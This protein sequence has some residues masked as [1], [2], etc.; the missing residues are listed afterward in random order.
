LVDSKSFRTFASRK[1]KSSYS[2]LKLKEIRIMPAN[3]EMVNGVASFAENGKRERAWHGLGQVV[4]EPMFVADALKLCHADFNVG[5]QPVVALSQELIEAMENHTF[6]NA[7]MLKDLLVENTM[8]TMRQDTNKSLGI[9]SDKYGIVQNVDA[10]KFVDLFCSGEKTDR[11]HTPVIETCG[12]LG[13]GERI[14]V[15]AKFPKPIVLDAKRDDLVEMYVVFTT[16]HDGTGAVR[17]VCTPVRVVCNNTLN[18]AMK[19]NIG[20]IAFRHSSKVMDRLDLLNAENAE[21]AYKALNVAEVYANGLKESF[22]HLRNIK[23]AE[24]D[25]DNIIAQVVLSDEA[26]KEFMQTRNIESELIKTRGRNI[27][28]GV[29]ECL[30]SGIGQEGQ[31][32]GTAMWLMNGLTSFYQNEATERSNE[33][34][35]DSILDGN[36]YKKVQKAY[37][38]AIAA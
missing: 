31:E 26:A 18:W 38:L 3:I 5:L 35:F 34:K 13:K 29:K 4:E 11:D 6:I 33:I 14:F 24:R 12:V 27:F 17:C 19:E 28:L 30:E 7:S 22:D 36:I 23:L 16:T 37:D 2:Q 8:A 10:F 15:T 20:R 1:Q 21:F 25:L 9:V 32:R